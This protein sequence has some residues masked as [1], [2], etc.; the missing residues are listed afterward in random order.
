M[1]LSIVIGHFTQTSVSE[2]ILEAI[3]KIISVIII[4]ASSV[5]LVPV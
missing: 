3:V 1:F 4:V 5:E 2:Q